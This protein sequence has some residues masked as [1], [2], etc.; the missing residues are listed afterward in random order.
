MEDTFHLGAKALL[1]NDGKVLLLKRKNYWD[2]PGGRVEKKESVLDALHR[3]L[4]EEIGLIGLTGLSH[5]MMVLSSVRI[6]RP[7][8]DVG[9]ILT[10][11]RCEIPPFTPQLSEEH[12][13]FCWFSPE[14][15]KAVLKDRY[16]PEF[17]QQLG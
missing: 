6:P 12:T 15:A 8:G 17:I 9:L 5:F 10:V 4:Q 7:D 13:D 11:Y 16:P 1:W 2:I 3:E 14:E